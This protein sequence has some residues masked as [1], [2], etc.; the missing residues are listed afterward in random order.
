MA[1]RTR[2]SAAGPW[3][4]FTV[5]SLAE[6][7]VTSAS[8]LGRL[9]SMNSDQLWE[10]VLAREE[11]TNGLVYA[12]CTT[13]VFC[14]PSCPS[15]R[16]RRENVTFFADAAAAQ[17]A[18]FRPC[19]RCRPDSSPPD[20]NFERVV[21]ACSA[22][23]LA[24]GTLS[25]TKLAN[26]AR[27]SERQLHRAFDEVVATT[28]RAFASAVRVGRARAALRGARRVVD[29]IYAADFASSRGFYET[30][31]PTLGMAPDA[32]RRGGADHV[33]RYTVVDT[34]AGPA[35]IAASDA[36]LCAVHLGVADSAAIARLSNEFPRARVERA[37]EEL[38]GAALAVASLA[39]G[40]D[41]GRELPLDVSATAFQARVWAAL[42]RIPAGETRSYTDVARE[43]GEPRAARAVARA[44]ATNRLALVVPCHRVVRANGQLGGYRWGP[45]L[46][47]ALLEAESAECELE[48]RGSVQARRAQVST[49]VPDVSHQGHEEEQP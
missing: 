29:A 49:P 28:P 18:G 8:L 34:V 6:S 48:A 7:G 32:Y 9:L 45:E 20:L 1:P 27:T 3:A 10:K 12:V 43:I 41:A 4:E 21:L 46:K 40:R 5:D 13:G 26:V 30:V 11:S 2:L 35:V 24:G 37:D 19:R 31:G 36:G 14:R 25:V 42:R 15:R 44:C 47:S 39:H 38:A 17:R 33:L 23:L 16:P 22:Q